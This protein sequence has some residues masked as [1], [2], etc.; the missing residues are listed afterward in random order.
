LDKSQIPEVTY[1]D[2]VVR[3]K[4]VKTHISLTFIYKAL[5]IGLSYLLVPLTINYLNIEQYGIWMTLLS[6]MSWVAFFD[7][8]LGNGLRNKLAEAVSLN[9]IKL[10]RTYV[11][12]AYLA[13]TLIALLFFFILILALPFTPWDKIFNTASVTNT[14]LLKVVFVVGFFFLFNF[15]LSLCNQMFYA[16]QEA[17][18]ATLR[19]VLLNLFALIAIY[20]LIHHAS[21][22]LLY[23]GICY[24]LSMVL[25]NLILIFYF[26]KKHSTVIPSKKYIELGKIREIAFLGVKF[27]IIQIAVLVIFATD[28][29][30]ITQILGPA[31]V[32]S[33]NVVFKLFSVITIVHGIMIAPLWSAY[34][35]A[36]AK[37]DTNWIRNTLKKLNL[38]MIPIMIAVSI[39]IVFAK[40]IINIWVGPEIEFPCLL[41]V[42]MGVYVI[43]SVWNNIYAYFVNGIGRITPQLYSAIIAGLINIP[44]SVYFAKSLAM[45]IN[46]V[47]LG[48][49]VSLFLF[50][51]IGP[52]QTYYIVKINVFE[53]EGSGCE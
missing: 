53:Q 27:F 33:Y 16:Y 3:T 40:D 31:E 37:G 39:L 14:E 45:G 49:I 42:L 43:I 29:M 4:V 10:A 25:S 9:S 2:S 5:A 50:A 28:N 52:I 8:G 22:N 11:S 24:G 34:T 1:F 18:L 35:D 41:A 32:T 44:L 7:I 26:F 47:I 36:Y 13:V 12:T 20:I 17:S 19:S 21:G 48:T 6:V 38:L 30:I 51:I 46:G 23:L 15:V